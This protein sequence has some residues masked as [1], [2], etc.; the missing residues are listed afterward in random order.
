MHRARDGAPTGA[1]GDEPGIFA[2]ED[3]IAEREGFEIALE[4]IEE[5]QAI[6]GDG[7]EPGLIEQ[8]LAREVG[9]IGGGQQAESAEEAV[10]A[11]QRDV[12]LGERPQAVLD[13]GVG[14]LVE[15]RRGRSRRSWCDG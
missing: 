13:F 14:E 10:L 15:Q 4:G 3:Q 11:Q 12:G 6:K 2:R 9:A 5:R 8:R 1:A 7:I